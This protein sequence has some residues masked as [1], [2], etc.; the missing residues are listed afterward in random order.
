MPDPPLS[1][2]PSQDLYDFAAK[3]RA[4][5]LDW[6]DIEKTD[7]DTRLKW[8]GMLHRAKRTPGRFMMRLRTPNGI[9]NSDL[10]RF[11]ADSVEPYGPEIGVVDITTRQNIQLRGVTLE[12][13]AD[14]LDGLHN[15]NQTSIQSALDNVRNMVGSPLAGIDEL[16]MVDTRPFCNA[17]SDLISLDPKTGKRGN[18]TWGNLPRKF[19]VAVSGGRDDYA[20]T[21]INDI[22]LQPCKHA[23]TG[24]MGFNVILG[25]YMSIKRVAESV[26]I[27][28]WIPAEVDQATS[29][30]YA[31]LTIFRDKGARGDRQKARMMWLIEEVGIPAFR[32]MI[33]DEMAKG[34]P[35]RHD[36]AQPQ[37]SAPYER[38]ELLGVHPQPQ[39][40]LNR[41]GIH[42]PVG[43]LSATECREIA[44]LADKYS[45]GEV[46]LTVE[47]NIILPNVADGQLDALLAEPS[48]N[49]DS[50][51]DVKPGHI[52]G[53][54]VSCT[55][56]Q[57]CG[58]AL[59]ETKASADRI[60]RK[61]DE[62]VSVKKP[63]RIHWTGCPN[64]CGQ[65]Q[66]AD[67]GIM[68]GPAKKLD[69]ET[70]KNKAVPGCNIFVGGKIGEDSHLSL[71]PYKKGVPLEDEDL[72]PVLVDIA[73]EH[74]GATKK[75]RKRDAVGD[76]FKNLFGGD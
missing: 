30:S 74:F 18:P 69:P 46:R 53:N 28:M 76:F 31:I 27:D 64:S 16:E 60:A 61:L 22:G 6:E 7:M 25:G 49:G 21:H 73:I 75:G 72:L 44:D 57:F 19:N 4:G 68:G 37:D 11:Y 62:L 40:G 70:G 26:P 65:A 59:V 52:I 32:Q 5:T 12:D 29:L 23:T 50:R 56:A 33:V 13:A 42:V 45:G 38:R 55:G 17:L 3:I 66:A 41:V 2:S 51:L 36:V 63:L 34:A 47:Q 8:C 9:V 54:T 14:V 71:D 1:H 10:M 67:I 48:L 58:L 20:H 24:E 43:R 39:S 15:R 35:V